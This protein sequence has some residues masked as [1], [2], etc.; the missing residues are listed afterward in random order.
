LGAIP[1][2]DFELA[3]CDGD[4]SAGTATAGKEGMERGKKENSLLRRDIDI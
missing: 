1:R 4:Y 2:A 3:F